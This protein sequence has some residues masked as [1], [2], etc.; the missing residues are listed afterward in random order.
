VVPPDRLVV[1]ICT[2]GI[3]VMTAEADLVGSAT[4]LAVTVTVLV[5]EIAGGA[6]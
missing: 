2:A 5:D 1:V 6:V 4:L 3:R